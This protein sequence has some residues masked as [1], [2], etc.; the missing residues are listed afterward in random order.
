MAFSN[1]NCILRTSKFSIKLVDGNHK[2]AYI[3]KLHLLLSTLSLARK[4]TNLWIRPVPD[5]DCLPHGLSET[6]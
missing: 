4:W 6:Q 1:S 5:N 2:H 3:I